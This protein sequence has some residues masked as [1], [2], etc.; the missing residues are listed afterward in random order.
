MFIVIIG[1]KAAGKSEIKEY[2]LRRKG[3]REVKLVRDSLK[4]KARIKYF[5]FCDEANLR[6]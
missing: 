3:F 2:L 4:E 6:S 5:C 1:T